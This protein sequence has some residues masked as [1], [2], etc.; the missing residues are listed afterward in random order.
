M[1]LFAALML[2][3]DAGIR[4]SIA[5]TGLARMLVR[6]EAPTA[7]ARRELAK[8]GIDWHELRP[9]AKN[10]ADVIDLLAANADEL[11]IRLLLGE[12]AERAFYAIVQQGTDALR[13]HARELRQQHGENATY[14]RAE[15]SRLLPK[16]QLRDFA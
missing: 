9:S 12:R 14:A 8:L 2:L 11:T 13:K 1:T 5:G 4:A 3:H 6:L 16:L 7:Q 10:L 15:I